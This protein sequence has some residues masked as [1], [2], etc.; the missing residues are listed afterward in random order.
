M[1]NALEEQTMANNQ[2]AGQISPLSPNSTPSTEMTTF[3]PA[4]SSNASAAVSGASSK[5]ISPAEAPSSEPNPQSIENQTKQALSSKTNQESKPFQ[6][7]TT[8]TSVNKPNI[9]KN[10]PP[11]TLKREKT[12]PAIG[13]SSDQPILNLKELEL[14]GPILLIT[15]LLTTGARHPYKIDEKYLAKRN[16]KVDGSSPVNISVYTL[17]E[18][19]WREWRNGKLLTGVKRILHMLTM[20]VL[21]WE[22]RPSSP[23]SIRLIYY[24]KLL[25]D[26]SRLQGETFEP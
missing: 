5:P 23:S 4:V 9:P 8:N 20:V 7:P 25:E 16:V 2:P 13:P 15:L 3:P 19:I 10:L 26:K 1:E 6:E 11:H 17:K 21:D 18:L 24:G 22:A 14:T 12:G